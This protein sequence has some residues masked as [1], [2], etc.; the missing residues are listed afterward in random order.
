MS[1]DF[2]TSLRGV[3]APDPYRDPVL[4]LEH[5]VRRIPYSPQS[6]P[7]RIRNSPWL[8]E[9]LQALIDPEVQELAALGPV[10]SGKSWLLEAASC[11]IPILMPGPTLILQ[12]VD[13]NASDFLETRLRILWESIPAVRGLLSS[14][15]IPKQGAI[16]FRGNTCWVL[17]A[18]N[19]RNLQRRSIRFL[20]CDEVWQYPSGALKEALARVTAYKWQSKSVFV[21][22]G[23]EEGGKGEDWVNYWKTTDQR[24]WTF[25]CPECGHR[26]PYI[27]E[28][29]KY[30]ERAKRESG[31]NLDI[32]R[33]ETVYCC[34]KCKTELKDSNSVRTKLNESGQ[35]IA[36]NPAAPKERRGYHWNALC[37]QW[38]L[39]W[40]DLAVECIEARR[41]YDERSDEV[42]RKEFFQKRMAEHWK[43]KT[44]EVQI[45]SSVGE[46]IIQEPWG[47]EA[48]F[49]KGKPKAG[50]SL[51]EDEKLAPEFVRCRFMGV[52]VQ[53]TGFYWVVRSWNGEGMSR[54]YDF[55]YCNSWTELADI[56]KRCDV[57]PANVFVDCGD[58]KDE[59]LSACGIRGWCATR[60]DQRNEFPWKIRLPNGSVKTELRAYSTPSIENAGGKRVKVFYF[61]NLRFKDTLAA[62]IRKGKHTR[63]SNVSQEYI[64]QMTSEKRV[65][66]GNSKPIW[67]QIGKRPNHLW[68]CEVI[69]LLP[70]LAWRLTGRNVDLEPPSPTEDAKDAPAT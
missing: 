52:D 8:K 10:Q 25:A 48:G 33:T 28:G 68:D 34:Q 49:V 5:Y 19:Q 16:N 54:L 27:W 66:A 12:D 37:G 18:N 20:L 42:P 41:V 40:G 31:W 13:K 26:Q 58:Q 44:D 60:G 17:G 32:V 4:F 24:V 3:L 55:G 59:V 22:Q 21:S 1:D 63:P 39:S 15:G 53:R 36:T 2:S 38:G 35:Y 69:G 45:E 30:P 46:Y 62:L 67:E 29:I 11:I 61:S 50:K 43:E 7:F 56:Q 57:H 65:L 14:D 64:E 47:E 23:G 70:A 6:G 9:P 51:T